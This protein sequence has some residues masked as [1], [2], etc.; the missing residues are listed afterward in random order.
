MLS[1]G[2][3]TMCVD[4]V[5]DEHMLEEVLGRHKSQV[6]MEVGFHGGFGRALRNRAGSTVTLNSFSYCTR[7]VGRTTSIHAIR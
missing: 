1:F 3:E 2:F 6:F 4:R 5:D 7:R